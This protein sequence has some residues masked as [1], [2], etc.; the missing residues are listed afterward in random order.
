MEV[1]AY[2][3]NFTFEDELKT[4]R[5]IAYREINTL[6]E[7]L[8]LWI[9]DSSKNLWSKHFYSDSYLEKVVSFTKSRPTIVAHCRDPILWWG[10][11]RK[12]IEKV[13]NEK[14]TSFL[15]RYELGMELEGSFL[16]EDKESLDLLPPHKKYIF[17]GLLGFSG[18]D[19]V[20]DIKNVAKL[21]FPIIVEP[22]LE[23][24]QDIGLTF[25]SS[26]E[27]F[28]IENFNDGGGQFKGG[29]LLGVVPS[30]IMN[31]GERIF[32]W[33]KENFDVDSLQ[34][35]MFSYLEQEN[36]KLS[37]NYLCEV[38]HRKTMGWVLW[39][40]QS[41]FKTKYAAFKILAKN[42]KIVESRSSLYMIELS[43]PEHKIK[44]IFI[45]SDNQVE[46]EDCLENLV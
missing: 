20:R 24:Q 43:P 29:K 45:G 15:A 25:L 8:F 13:I 30:H 18:R 31:A 27:T 4:S 40:L 11:S 16:A 10:N 35:D 9:E 17:K 44:V 6:F 37:W 38:N 22:L 14:K 39:K 33:Y 46:F 42:C 7:F 23:R 36:K 1:K 34:I 26:S 41:I 32:K 19:Q 5:P 3:T 21:K 28:A 12:P 2:Y